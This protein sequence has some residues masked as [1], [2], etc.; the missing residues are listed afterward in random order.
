MRVAR[1]ST[2]ATWSEACGLTRHYVVGLIS[3]REDRSVGSDIRT[4]AHRFLPFDARTKSVS[5]TWVGGL[6]SYMGWTSLRGLAQPSR[7]SSFIRLT[8]TKKAATVRLPR[9]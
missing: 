8:T 5:H 2:R 6:S 4:L 9:K 7:E 1:T 3:L